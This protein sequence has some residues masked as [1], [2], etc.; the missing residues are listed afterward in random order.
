MGLIKGNKVLQKIAEWKSR[1]TAKEAEYEESN[2]MEIEYDR[3]SLQ[4]HDTRQRQEYIKGFLEQ[5]ADATMELENLSFEYGT[6]TSY[7]KDMEEIEAL[8]E[9]EMQEIKASA[10]K[11]DKLENERGVYLQKKNRMSDEKFHQMERMEDEA[12]EA[13]RKLAEAEEDQNRIKQDMSRLDGEKHAFLYRKDELKNIIA[14]SKGMA[15]IC[16]VAFIICFVVLLVLQYGMDMDTQLGFLLAA[17]IAALIITLLYMRHAEAVKELKKVESGINR[18]IQLQNRVKIRYVN[19]TN[20]LDYL[21]LKYQVSSAKEMSTLWDRYKIEREERKKYRQA[22]LELDECQ[23]DLLNILKC[24]QIKDPA[25]WLHQ[26]AALLDSKE[27][28]EIRHNLIIRRQS[29]RRRIDYN[30]E[31]IIAGAQ[32]AIKDMADSYPEY[33]KEIMDMVSEYEREQS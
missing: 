1:R 8:P 28:V 2:W 31:I 7:L 14:D 26:T 6:V 30:K 25:I 17:G 9:E 33:A 19:N 32:N 23:Q 29:L 10:E 16:G 21:Y 5:I 24:Y 15:I 12:E 22:E 4:V 20:L 18:L 27:M 3:K 13:C 11:I